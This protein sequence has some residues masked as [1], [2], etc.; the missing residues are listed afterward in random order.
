[1][2]LFMT[3]LLCMISGSFAAYGNS[4]A[5]VSYGEYFAETILLLLITM[6]LNALVETMIACLMKM[7][8]VWLVFLTNL[9]TNLVMNVVLGYLDFTYSLYLFKV[10]FPVLCLFEILVIGV[11]YGIYRH[12]MGERTEKQKILAYVVSANV[13]TFLLGLLFYQMMGSGLF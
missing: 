9:V 8:M 3:V 13:C 11:E 12:M 5:P 10:Y 6:V 7:P 4:P 1:M 2:T